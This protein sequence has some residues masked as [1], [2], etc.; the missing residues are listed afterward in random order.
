M[1]AARFIVLFSPRGRLGFLAL[2]LPCKMNRETWQNSHILFCW[3]IIS[4]GFHYRS[5]SA[6][7]SRQKL[8][9]LVGSSQYSSEDNT[10]VLGVRFGSLLIEFLE[11]CRISRMPFASLVSQTESLFFLFFP[12]TSSCLPFYYSPSNAQNIYVLSQVRWR[13]TKSSLPW[14]KI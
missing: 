10:W 7:W 13:W 3:N 4:Y 14:V 1:S 8:V 5:V 2:G 9:C 12:S 6:M 11:L